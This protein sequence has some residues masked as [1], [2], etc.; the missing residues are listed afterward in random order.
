MDKNRL[1]AAWTC[2]S[3]RGTA[4]A[5]RGTISVAANFSAMFAS[6]VEIVVFVF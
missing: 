5:M 1:R 3:N 4:E 6:E 2:G